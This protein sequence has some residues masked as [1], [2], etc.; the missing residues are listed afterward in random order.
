MKRCPIVYVR[1][2]NPGHVD[3]ACRSAREFA[4]GD[5]VLIADNPYASSCEY[6]PASEFSMLSNRMNHAY[7]HRSK[8][9]EPFEKVC[10]ARWAMIYEWA[11]HEGVG[12]MLCCDSDV[13]LFHDPFKIPL[14]TELDFDYTLSRDECYTA[15][16][17]YHTT[18]DLGRFMD[19]CFEGF[20]SN[21]EY[22][23]CDMIAWQWFSYANK[24]LKLQFTEVPYKGF[25]LD[26]HLGC[27]N[28]WKNNGI[29]KV[30]TWKDNKPFATTID[31]E[32]AALVNMHC[33]SRFEEK[34]PEYYKLGG[35]KL[36]E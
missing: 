20:S 27:M 22:M 4:N 18:D 13:M 1:M 26:H 28:G 24:D 5:V 3:I 15:G 11:L 32:D 25:V 17:S 16:C 9:P 12:D 10:F 31:G 6:V 7:K 2:W 21:K 23:W 35:G 36:N 29:G 14:F 19:F 8:L 34:M 33:W 30:I